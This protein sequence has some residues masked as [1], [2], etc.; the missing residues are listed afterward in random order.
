[1]SIYQYLPRHIWCRTPQPSVWP[2]W[3]GSHWSRSS[4]HQSC[5]SSPTPRKIYHYAPL[6]PIL[7]QSDF[8]P[9]FMI[10][11]SLSNV[12]CPMFIVQCSL[13]NVRCPMFI[14]QCSFHSKNI[15]YFLF[16]SNSKKQIILKLQIKLK[17]K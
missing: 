13:S 10:Q 16:K 3:A 14:V 15:C 12:H 6:H 5:S 2:P 9:M 1:M 17:M 4:P 7:T 11:C 8:F